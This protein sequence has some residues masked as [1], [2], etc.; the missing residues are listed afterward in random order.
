FFGRLWTWRH[1]RFSIRKR[2]WLTS[3]TR[4]STVRRFW[5][6]GSA[7]LKFAKRDCVNKKKV[8]VSGKIV[9]LRAEKGSQNARLR[10]GK[11][12]QLGPKK[13]VDSVQKIQMLLGTE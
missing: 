4:F 12:S 11:G 13:G 10:V 6:S 1:S 3:W 7:S 5:R 8:K 2:D 9:R